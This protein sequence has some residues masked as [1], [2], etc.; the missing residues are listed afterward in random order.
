VG[1]GLAEAGGGHAMHRVGGSPACE[2]AAGFHSVDAA[3]LRTPREGRTIDGGAPEAGRSAK[4]W[5]TQRIW[6][7]LHRK[8]QAANAQ[9][10][11]AAG[12]TGGELPV[13]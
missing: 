13:D 7:F 9:G 11:A 5:S 12:L 4:F 10:G 1:R 3:M 6:R 2:L 8:R